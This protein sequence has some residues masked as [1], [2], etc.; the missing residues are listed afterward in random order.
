[1]FYVCKIGLYPYKYRI[2]GTMS[3]YG[4][5][6]GSGDLGRM[7]IYFQEAGEHAHLD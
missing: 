2:Y 3:I 7:D 6:G 4:T 5:P 1:M